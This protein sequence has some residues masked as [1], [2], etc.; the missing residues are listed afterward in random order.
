MGKKIGIVSAKGGVGKTITTINLASALMDFSKSVVAVDGDV[1]LSGL[2]LQLGMYYFPVTLNDVLDGERS[3]LESLY[4]HSSGLRI[5]PASLGIKNDIN[6]TKLNDVLDNGILNDDVIL[7]DCPPGLEKNAISVIK[8]CTDVIIVT[9]PEIPA[10]ADVLKTVDMAR[11]NNCNVLGLIVNRYIK[12]NKQIRVSEIS[13]SCGLPILGVIPED[14]CLRRS[15][16]DR[17]PSILS[18]PYA[19]SSIEFKKIAASLVNYR[20]VP[21]KYPIIKRF[22]WKMKK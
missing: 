10:I 15:V 21:P 11:K 4:I 7:I 17:T 2:S 6:L 18:D 12:S 16:F 8:S 14:P 13:A 5:I 9:T 19:A 1:K 20:Y 22:L 3:V